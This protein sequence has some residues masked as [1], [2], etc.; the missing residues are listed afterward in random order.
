MLIKNVFFFFISSTILRALQN[1]NSNAIGRRPCFI[2]CNGR[3][4]TNRSIFP[5]RRKRPLRL[6]LW[7]N[8]W[9]Q[10]IREEPQNTSSRQRRLQVSLDRQTYALHIYSQVVTLFHHRMSFQGWVRFALRIR[11]ILY[12]VVYLFNC[13]SAVLL[14]MFIALGTR[15]LDFADFHAS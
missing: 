11:F 6:F 13:F 2:C 7:R 3:R 8:C 15:E 5:R 4:C 1:E 9:I 12:R 10:R 14:K